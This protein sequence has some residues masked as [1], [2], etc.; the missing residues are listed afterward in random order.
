MR[1]T[2]SHR[3][4]GV[5]AAGH[6]RG[7]LLLSE[8]NLKTAVGVALWVL[9]EIVIFVASFI[10]ELAPDD[11]NFWRIALGVPS[12]VMAVLIGWVGLKAPDRFIQ[13]AVDLMM[14]PALAFHAVLLNISPASELILLNMLVI[15]I[16]AGYFV[17]TPAL[18]ATLVAG[19]AL[20]ISACF[21]G[22]GADTPYLNSFVVIYL[23]VSWATALLLHIQTNETNIA[24]SGARQRAY[25]DPLT[26]LANLRWLERAAEKRLSAKATRRANTIPTL[27]LIDLVNFKSA[28]TKHGHEGGDYALRMLATQLRRVAPNGSVVARTGGDE[29]AVFLDVNPGA[30]I[31]ETKELFRAA[32]RAACS[33]FDL[34]GV[35]IDAAIGSAR[36]PEDGRDLSELLD[37][38]DRAMHADKGSKRHM[39]PDLESRDAPDQGTRAWADDE[40]HAVNS[41]IAPLLSL[42]ALT[43]G[44]TK[45]LA[46]RTPYARFSAISQG[47]GALMLAVSLAVPGAYPDPTLT[48]W[49]ALIGG[50]LLFPTTLLVNP[51]PNTGLHVVYD[52]ASLV[53]IAAAVA[54][55]GGIESTASALLVLLVASQAWF[56]QTDHVTFRIVGP[57]GVA[58]APLTYSTIADTANDTLALLTLIGLAMLLTVLVLAMY[59]NR[60]QLVGLQRRAE[61][62]SL[63]DPMTEIPNRRAFG[64]FVKQLLAADDVEKFAVVM[65]DLDNFKRVNTERGHRAGDAV[66]CA[67][68]DALCEIARDDDCIARIGGDEFAAVLPGVGVEAARVFAERLIDAIA[69]TPEAQ[70]SGVTASAGF[71]LSPLHGDTLEKLVFTADTA[72]MAVKAS[73]KDGGSSVAR[74]VSA[75]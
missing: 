6:S 9:T 12:I 48:W 39:V 5:G 27:V 43:G 35:K 2:S 64:E 14:A 31:D 22:P 55:T 56:W 69:A 37:V 44:G 58:L 60:S 10:P 75:L 3:S 19:S 1:K 16:Y 13:P 32:V 57:V 24:L 30:N 26:G 17:R 15:F 4:V 50:V 21:I 47:F 25:S 70:R 49:M 52:F 28:N 51:K 18:I 65:I 34:P 36:F 42:D 33:I 54:M 11:V 61:L 38:A 41:A 45:L 20:A 68:A 8:R 62:L 53:L 73:G 71:A 59:L 72:L 67:I 7:Q 66:I 29:F 40:R 23:G 74:I 46:S 63:R